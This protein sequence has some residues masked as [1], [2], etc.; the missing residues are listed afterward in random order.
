[1]AAGAS[2]VPKTVILRITS[3]LVSAM[4]VLGADKSLGAW[5]MDVHRLITARA[6]DGLPAPLHAFFAAR[7]AF[8][9]EHSV[10]P[11]LWRVVDARGELGPEDP[12]HFLNID[13]LDEAPPF[14]QVPREW[15]AFVAKYGAE[16]ANKTGRLPWRAEE[17]DAK[18]V[19]AFRAMGQGT[20]GHAADDA[21]YLA[22]ALAH[23]LEDAHVPFHATGNY[24]GQLT[25]QRGVHARF[26]SDLVLRNQT[27]LRLAR[28]SIRPMP[29]IVDEV[30]RTVVESQS[31]VAR[32]LD[33][34]KQA[35]HGRAIYDERYYS[36]F[37]AGV[38]PI[39]ERRL[40]DAASTVA[41]A[42]VAAWTEAGR[43]S[44]DEAPRGSAGRA[45]R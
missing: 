4:V 29:S 1:M 5:G 20:G 27:T 15:A 19:A 6:L 40:S 43:P 26:E 8:V 11:D 17:I 18:L 9:V 41:S 10:D 35:A 22:A 13:T 38:R 30:F 39:L 28:V 23:Y 12:N 33:A 37:L 24:D 31:L 42:I 7:R 34:E 32:V 2:S 21:R 16:R 36:E 25:N 44:L 3:V 14:R 45:Q